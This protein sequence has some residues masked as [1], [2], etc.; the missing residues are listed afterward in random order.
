MQT[1]SGN[2]KQQALAAE[3][4]K[5]ADQLGKLLKQA[6]TDLDKRVSKIETRSKEEA[7]VDKKLVKLL[8]D[9]G[10]KKTIQ[11]RRK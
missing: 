5:S 2:P 8:K 11:P 6:I 1:K 10:I 7:S 9:A 4:K 3:F